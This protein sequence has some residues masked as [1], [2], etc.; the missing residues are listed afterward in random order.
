[1][2]GSGVDL[3]NR[4]GE[5]FAAITH[6]VKTLS[7]AIQTIAQSAAQQA[8]NLSQINTV[9]G[10]LDRSTQQN[11]AM[12]EQCTA[13]CNLAF[14]GGQFARTRAEPLRDRP[15]IR[16]PGYGFDSATRGVMA[17]ARAIPA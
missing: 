13:R 17:G 6:D 2:S 11:A 4:S 8:E 16:Y 9:V 3:V 15:D 7:G 14:A 1:M 12:A 5:A 10:E